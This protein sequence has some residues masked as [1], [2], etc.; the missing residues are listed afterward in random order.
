MSHVQ[1]VPRFIAVGCTAAA[2][3]F[4]VVL[5]LVSFAHAAPLLANVGGWLLAFVVSF[6]GQWRF[7][8]RASAAPGWRSLRRYLAL[9]L[10]GFLANEAAYAALLHWTTLPYDVLL[11]IVLVA[12]AFGTYV[13]SAGWA[14]QGQRS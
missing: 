11:A 13:L 14:F 4:A 3:H 2:V 5:V 10:V 1:R 7:T 9:S 8:F 12:V 6:L